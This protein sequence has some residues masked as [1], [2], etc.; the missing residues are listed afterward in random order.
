MSDVRCS[1]KPTAKRR[2]AVSGMPMLESGAGRPAI[3][4]SL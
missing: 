4:E 3:V 2:K 1:R